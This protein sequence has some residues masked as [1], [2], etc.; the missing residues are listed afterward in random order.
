MP[1][2]MYQKAL[3]CWAS[4]LNMNLNEYTA[5]SKNGINATEKRERVTNLAKLEAE[6]RSKILNT[7]RFCNAPI[8]MVPLAIRQAP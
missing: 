5:G 7:T 4:T 3:S 1:P 6:V 8:Q 2:D